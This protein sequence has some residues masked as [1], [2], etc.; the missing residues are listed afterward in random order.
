MPDDIQQAT[1]ASPSPASGNGPQEHHMHLL[2]RYYRQVEAGRKTIE[3]R[4]AT[5]DKRT[6]AAG[7]T[8]VFHDRDTGRELDVTVQRIT[9]YPSF[10]DSA[11]RIPR[12]STR[13][14]RPGRCSPPS[15]ASTRPSRKRSAFS[16]SR[17][18]IALP[19]Q[20]APCR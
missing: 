20:G 19:G 6:V 14:D 4:V 10:K 3:V 15:A 18:T 17:S 11:R 13:T 5:P 2:G 16:P 8:V 1:A 12:T 7:D 9:S